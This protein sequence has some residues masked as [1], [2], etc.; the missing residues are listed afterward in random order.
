MTSLTVFEFESKKVRTVVLDGDIWFIVSDVLSAIGSGSKVTD[1]KALVCEDLGEEFVTV[2][3]LQTAGGVQNFVAF[4]E[5]GLTLFV[6]RSR[7]PLGKQL[8]RWLHTE[9]LPTLR[10]TGQ[11]STQKE[12]TP[13][14][15]PADVR[16]ANL[17]TSMETFERI[18]GK[19]NP[20]VQ[21]QFK[22]LV[23]NLVTESNQKAL[24]G[25]IEDWRGIVSLAEELGYKV[26]IK[27][28]KCRTKLGKFI[29]DNAPHLAQ[30]K[31]KRLCNEVQQQIYVYP[32]HKPEI[33]T[34]L[35]DLVHLFFK[36][37][38]AQKP[39]LFFPKQAIKI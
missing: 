5:P 29:A 36:E 4:S 27:G 30:H 18:C 2:V 28:D 31:E 11:Y 26:P 16:V 14:L 10:K 33:R 25:D 20:Y 13:Q 32:L 12:V 1:A 38:L 8:N 23:G 35:I 9:V 39:L 17:V 6:S 37:T 24:T 34:E 22:D 7:T 3:P 19:M 21:Q 15:P